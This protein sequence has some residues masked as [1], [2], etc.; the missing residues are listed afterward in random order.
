MTLSEW[1][2]ALSLRLKDGSAA[3][4]TEEEREAHVTAA[5]Q[6]YTRC[7]PQVRLA[8]VFTVAGQQ[9]YAL[10]ADCLWVIH[11]AMPAAPDPCSIEGSMRGWLEEEGELW[12][13]PV[14]QESGLPVRV[15]YAAA[16]APENVPQC[17]AEMVLLAAHARCCEVLATDTA[18]AFEFWV[19]SEKFDKSQVSAHYRELARDLRTQFRRAAAGGR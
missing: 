17:D 19:G 7:R 1:A 2:A 6:E 12:L 3:L 9:G 14:P 4:F 15:T 11:A 18:R 10:P 5:V 13:Y 16:W 8:E